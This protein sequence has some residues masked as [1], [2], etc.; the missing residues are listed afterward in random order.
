MNWKKCGK[1]QSQP[2]LWYYPGI[3]L[4]HLRKTMKNLLGQLVSRPR[5]EPEK[6]CTYEAGMLTTHP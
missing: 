1:K 3:C 2:N 6:S 5:F 4:D